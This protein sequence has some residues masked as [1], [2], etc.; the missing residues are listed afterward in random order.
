M[1]TVLANLKGAGLERTLAETDKFTTVMNR[2]SADDQPHI[3]WYVDPIA[4]VRRLA[5]GSLAAT[6]TL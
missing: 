1:E 6:G 3:A 5:S 4:L 2:C